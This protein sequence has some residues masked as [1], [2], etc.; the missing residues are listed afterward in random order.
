M[1]T[2]SKVVFSA[3]LLAL[4]L[5][6]AGV[7]QVRSHNP[8]NYGRATRHPARGRHRRTGKNH[9]ARGPFA[10]QSQTALPPDEDEDDD[11]RFRTDQPAACDSAPLSPLSHIFPRCVPFLLKLRR[12]PAEPLYQTLGI[13]LI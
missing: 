11:S 13:L 8:T 9:P 2:L 6:W 7:G 4:L 5:T 12:M 10:P 3:L 1:P